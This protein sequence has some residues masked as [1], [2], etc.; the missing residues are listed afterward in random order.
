MKFTKT[1]LAVAIAGLIAAPIA[2]A[3]VTLSGYVGFVLEGTDEDGDAG[4]LGMGGD[5]STLNVNAS[6]ELNSGLTGYGNWRVDAG[7]V[8]SGAVADNVH[9]GV[10]GGFGDVRIGEVPDALEYGQ[11]ANDALWDIGGENFGISYTGAFGPATVGL[12]WSPE[13]NGTGSGSVA[14]DRAGSDKIA[15]GIKFN[16]GGFGVGVGGASIGDDTAFSA[17][18]SFGIAG[19]SAAVAL[20]SRDLDATNNERST[21]SATLGYGV[22]NVSAKLSYAVETGDV[23]EDDNL[24]RLDLGY[25]LGGGMNLSTR[26]TSFTDDSDSAGDYTRFRVL[27]SK[28]F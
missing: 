7:L 12:N 3:D 5:D 2:S 11:K 8:G 10:K 20:K 4:N 24:I 16:A 14:G 13:G 22:G 6:H 27:M 23:N 21:L 1:A 17:G 26:I 9:I 19:A 15:A 25:G 18:A 28:D